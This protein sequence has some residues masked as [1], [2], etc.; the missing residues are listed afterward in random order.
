MTE[1]LARLLENQ[2]LVLSLVAIFSLAG[3]LAFFSMNRQEDPAFPYRAGQVITLF[4]GADPE[5]V[6]RLVIEPLEEQLAQVAEIDLIESVARQGVAVTDVRLHQTIYDTASAWDRV[7]VA[8]NAATADFPGGVGAPRLNDRVIGSSTIVYA[9]TG[10][11]D[12]L[13]LADAADRLKKRLLSVSDLQDIEIFG[14]PGEQITVAIDD[15]VIARTGLSPQAIVS[16]LQSSNRI[17]SGGSVRLSG[18]SVNLKPATDYRSLDEIR[19]TPIALPTGRTIPLGSIAHVYDSTAQPPTQRMWFDGTQAVGLELRAQRNTTNVV[20]FGERVRAKVDTLREEFAP[21]EIHEMFYQPAKTRERLANLTNSLFYSVLIIIAVLFVAMGLRMGLIVAALLPLVTLTTLAIYAFGGGVLHQIAVIAMVVSLGILVDNA[22]VMTE[23]VQYHLN[24]GRTPAQAAVLSVRELAG[25]LFAA[26]GTTLAAFVPLLLS[27]GGTADFTRAIPV[28]IMIALSVSYVFAVTLTPILSLHFLRARAFDTAEHGR[29]ARFADRL[30][31]F[32]T[33][34][35]KTMLVL[36]V[37][38]LVVSFACMRFLDQEFFPNAD[39]NQVVI[40]L[41]LAEGT[42][43]DTT[44]AATRKL[45]QALRGRPGVGSVH[46]FI[47]T[48]GPTFYYNLAQRPQSPQRSRLVVETDSLARNH[49]IIAWVDEFG[50]REL[51]QAN[52]VGGILRQG[53]PVT[54]PI[55]VRVFNDDPE[56][57]AAATEKVFSTLLSIPGARDVRHQLGTGVPSV[58]YE[59]NDAVARRFGVTRVDVAQALLGRSHGLV[60]GQYRAGDDP[61]PIKL[62][63]PQGERFDLAALETANIYAPDGSHVPLLQ[64]ATPTLEMQPGAIYHRDQRRIARVYSELQPGVPYSEVLNPARQRIGALELPPGTQVT[65]GGEAEESAKANNAIFET[66]PLGIAILLF[67]LLFEFNSFKRV[68]LVLLT[69]PFAMAGVIP[70]LLLLGYPF[71]FQPLLGIIALVGIVVNNAIVL[72]DVI[73][74]RLA[75]GN[76]ILDAVQEAVRRRTRPILLTTATTIAGL[77]PLALSDT[78]L[79]PPMAWAII[80]GL[81]A[82]T[83][84]TLLVLP[85]VCRLVLGRSRGHG[86]GAHATATTGLLAIALTAGLLLT[87]SGTVHADQADPASQQADQ[88]D[89]PEQ[90]SFNAAALMGSRRAGV[91]ADGHRAA[92][93]RDRASAEFRAG[94]LPTLQARAFAGRSDQVGSF[95]VPTPTGQREF[96]VGER[97]S[98]GA[99]IELRQPLLDPAQQFYATPAAEQ[100]A[101]AAASTYA[102]NKLGGAVR[103]SEAYLDALTLAE[104]LAVTDDLLDSLEARTTR[105]ARLRDA[106]RALKSDAL[107]VRFARDQARQSRAELIESLRVAQARLARAVGRDGRMAPEPL[108]FDPP[109]IESDVA[110]LLDIALADRRDVA[111]LNER[112]QAAELQA[113][114][115]SAGRLPSLDAVATMQYNEGNNF[116]PERERRIEAQLTWRPFAGGTLSARR[117]AALAEVAALRADRREFTREVRLQIEQAVADYRTAVQLQTLAASGIESARATLDTRSARYDAGRAN[118]DDV[119]DAEAELARQR[120]L[121]TIAG[122]DKLRAWVRLQGALA[123]SGWVRKL[124]E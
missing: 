41:T 64:V 48:G 73:D 82:S 78:T 4:P 14:D 81:L 59:I 36:G 95:S 62:R 83:V 111:A 124:P 50:A 97:N 109:A 72:I 86:R 5:R 32:T 93:A 57:L 22:I 34:Y 47:G 24:R 33:R 27:S 39:R 3:L 8:M 85:A 112:I 70:G 12:P 116:A 17:I 106:G 94:A 91:Q 102:S 23:N 103:A 19:A 15:A 13:A 16:N 90:I 1:R 87:P 119:L 44:E 38:V 74:H 114:A 100:Q 37:A 84:L 30:A 20:A 68:A 54:A 117:S 51:P 40:D 92:A 26:T 120:S 28:I 108:T 118:I 35:A 53:P 63:S 29:L 98:R 122:Y 76:N 71:G 25:P 46:A 79:W 80:T 75:E 42:H 10:D 52:L 18:A 115:I 61:V 2:K 107:E 9:L 121:R 69:L 110:A 96:T 56:G 55:E 77:L 31:G 113:D 89:K 104:R 123:R 6:E 88:A 99:T 49:E 101:R 66:A 67:F 11:A 60:I 43:L 21:L 7:R 45:E 65:F 58:D 105:I